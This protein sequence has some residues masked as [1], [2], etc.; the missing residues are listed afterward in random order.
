MTT[1]VIVLVVTGWI[2]L[3]VVAITAA[4]VLS[5]RLHDKASDANVRGM[6]GWSRQDGEVP[7]T[8]LGS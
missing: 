4:C 2:L 8:P 1:A 3:C 6:S 5:A 7:T